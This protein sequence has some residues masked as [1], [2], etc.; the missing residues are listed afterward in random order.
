M[1]DGSFNREK[2]SGFETPSVYRPGESYS[3]DGGFYSTVGNKNQQSGGSPSGGSYRDSYGGRD[4]Y[5]DSGFRQGQPQR[6]TSSSYG[7]YSSG[8]PQPEQPYR[9]ISY[10]SPRDMDQYDRGYG[11]RFY[12]YQDGDRPIPAPGSLTRPP[13][14]ESVGDDPDDMTQPYYDASFGQAVSRFF[15]RAFDFSGKSGRREYWFVQLFGLLVGFIPVTMLTIGLFGWAMTVPME[16]SSTLGYSDSLEYYSSPDYQTY[17]MTGFGTFC[18]LGGTILCL[19]MALAFFL[20]NLSLTVRR[21]RD[22]GFPPVVVGLQF[23]PFIGWIA[24]FAVL[25]FTFMPTKQE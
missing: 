20:P 12:R 23:V 4:S 15:R 11:S 6:D 16:D 22:A 18:L 3:T 21:V 14:N 10:G 8:Y 9:N 1:T 5:G 7:G 13:R 25:F 2:N 17:E 19:I 24:S